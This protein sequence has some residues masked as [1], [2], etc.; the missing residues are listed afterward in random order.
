MFER[1]VN[2]EKMK[3]RL[4]DRIYKWVKLFIDN[5]KKSI[6]K[7]QLKHGKSEQVFKRLT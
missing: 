1:I 6:N 7:S 4:N 3:L 2:S 5:L